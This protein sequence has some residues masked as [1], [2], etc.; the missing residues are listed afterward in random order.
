MFI[1]GQAS[2]RGVPRVILARMALHVLIN[3]VVGAIPIVGDMFSIFYRSNLKNLE[4][5]RR[6][7][8]QRQAAG[9]K[10]WFFVLGFAFLMLVT[11]VALVVGAVMIVRKLVHTL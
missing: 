8:G 11:V 10:D 9:M 1:I 6:Y 7:E 4:L 5:L 2:R 3:T